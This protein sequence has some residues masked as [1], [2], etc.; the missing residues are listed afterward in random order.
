VPQAIR[1]RRSQLLDAMLDG[2]FY[3]GEKKIAIAAEPDLLLSY[4]Q[5][6][7]DMGATITTAVSPTQNAVLAK[8]PAARVVIG[9]LDDL[10]T[11]A[12]GCDLV[13]SHSHG[14]RVAERLGATFFPAGFPVFDRLGAAHRLSVGYRGTRDLIFDIGNLF[15]AGHAPQGGDHAATASH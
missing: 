3:F 4:A 15:I 13:I 14:R 9:D 7:A 8:V 5:F 1:R 10:E 12:T 2:H 11:A 6:L